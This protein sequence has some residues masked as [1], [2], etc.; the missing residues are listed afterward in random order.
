MYKGIKYSRVV[1]LF[2]L[3]R[4][5]M[6]AV[7]AD[8][9]RPGLAVQRRTATRERAVRDQGLPG[10]LSYS[11]DLGMKFPFSHTHVPGS[12]LNAPSYARGQTI[13][14]SISASLDF[15]LHTVSSPHFMDVLCLSCAL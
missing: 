11:Y 5:S 15:I 12:F 2:L 13:L 7:V 6:S 8:G 3:L 10:R 1:V 9:E 4:V 14:V